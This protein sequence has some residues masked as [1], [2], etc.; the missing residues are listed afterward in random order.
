MAQLDLAL[1]SLKTGG[2]DKL[3]DMVNVQRLSNNPIPLERAK[4]EELYRNILRE[5]R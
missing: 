5:R 4:I 1:P 2:M 3:V